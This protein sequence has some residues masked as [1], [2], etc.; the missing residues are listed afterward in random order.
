MPSDTPVTQVHRV[1]GRYALY[2]V[3]AS[4]GMATVH[5]GRLQGPVGFSRTVAVKRLH[6]HLASDPEFVAMFLDEARLAAR[7]R[8]PNVVPTLDVVAEAGEIF[9]VMDYVQGESLAYLLK[10]SRQLEKIPVRV[11]ANVLVGTLEGLHAAHEAKSERGEPLGIVHRDVSPHNILVGSDGVPRVVDFGVAKA[12]GRLASTR[13]GVVKGKFAYMPPE[14]VRGEPLDRRTDVYAAS[15]VLWEALTARRLFRADSDVELMYRVLHGEIAP[16]SAFNAEVPPELDALVLRGLSRERDARFA[17]ASEMALALERCVPTV[18]TRE[19]GAWVQGVAAEHLLDR[20][21]QVEAIER[22]SSLHDLPPGA[23]AA[24]RVD[25]PSLHTADAG[26]SRSTAL[27]TSQNSSAARA[28]SGNRRRAWF[29]LGA[30]AS[31]AVIAVS[32]AKML[33]GPAAAPLP[34]SAS[35]ESTVSAP[36]VSALASVDPPPSPVASAPPAPS[37]SAVPSGARGRAPR[38]VAPPKAPPRPNLF[39]RD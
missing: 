31:A 30:I 3:I 15:V 6:A 18:P 9:L 20:A 32:S 8:H 19:V 1:V 29:V 25:A 28:P 38:P 2:D 22:M 17:T 24:P 34:G 13:E 11:V 37:A 39:T 7:I 21:R 14:Q 26:D 16:P 33:S 35:A 5:Y 36:P 4:G 27:S 12:I 10:A 23:A